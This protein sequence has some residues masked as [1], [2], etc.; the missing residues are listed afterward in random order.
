MAGL[1]LS[2]DE[3][4]KFYRIKG[5][6]FFNLQS[7]V[8]KEFGEKK[9][10]I[11]FQ[12]V[13]FTYQIVTTLGV[14]AGFGFFALSFVNKITSFI[15]GEALL[16]CAIVKGIHLVH[17]TYVGE[18]ISLDEAERKHSD[19]FYE[20]RKVFTDVLEKILE[21]KANKIDIEKLNKKDEEIK[22]MFDVS[23]E[24]K[25]GNSDGIKNL[26]SNQRIM[27]YLAVGGFTLILFSLV[28]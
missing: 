1:K 2:Q 13:N 24:I 16:F 5:S 7:N 18:L 23:K 28:F 19:E 9:L 11:Y 21:D 14:L 3:K 15:F 12:L 20:R 17:K 10:N 27:I 25:K 4:E 22:Q 8:I 26:A 6:K